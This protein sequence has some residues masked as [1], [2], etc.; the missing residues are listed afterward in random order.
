M[1]MK[2]VHVGQLLS[3]PMPRSFRN[4]HSSEEMLPEPRYSVNGHTTLEGGGVYLIDAN[5]ELPDAYFC[6]LCL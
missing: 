1:K 5:I 3:D 2:K 6:S 4:C